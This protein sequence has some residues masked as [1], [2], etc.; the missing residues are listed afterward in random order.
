MLIVDVNE[1]KA[2]EITNLKVLF[3]ENA[4]AGGTVQF[5]TVVLRPQARIPLNGMGVHVQDEY[6]I[7]IKGS[8][9]TGVGGSTYRLKK[10]QAT[11]IPA[12]E[13][14][15]SFNEGKEDCEIVWALVGR[16]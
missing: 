1:V 3:S 12:G 10:G 2:H 9:V 8:V 15:W 14:H 13:A 16:S 5:G 11:L 7:I 6:S 4:T